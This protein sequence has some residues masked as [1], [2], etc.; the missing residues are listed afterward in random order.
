MWIDCSDE[1]AAGVE[2]ASAMA[3]PLKTNIGKI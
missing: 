3:P 1:S 2:A